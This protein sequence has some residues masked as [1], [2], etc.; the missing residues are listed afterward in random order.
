MHPAKLT[1]QALRIH[2]NQEFDEMRR[3]MRAAMET[4]RD[5]GAL[6]VLTVRFR[7]FSSVPS[8]LGF[9]FS[10]RFFLLRRMMLHHV[11]NPA[12][13]HSR[14]NSDPPNT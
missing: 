5:G 6:G 14:A 13:T 4:M 9:S 8:R 10:S 3:G 7:S 2:L 1:F 12:N 11:V